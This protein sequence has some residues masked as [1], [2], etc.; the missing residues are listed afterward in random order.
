VELASD[1]HSYVCNFEV[2][3]RSFENLSTP[4]LLAANGVEDVSSVPV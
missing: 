2:A 1:Y 3:P 4:D